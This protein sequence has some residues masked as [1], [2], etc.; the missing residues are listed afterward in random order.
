[1]NGRT[2][3]A[4]RDG[5]LG[6]WLFM[7]RIVHAI[8][9]RRLWDTYPYVA[10]ACRISQAGAVGFFHAL[11]GLFHFPAW[12]LPRNERFSSLARRVLSQRGGPSSPFPGAAGLFRF[13]SRC[14]RLSFALAGPG[15]HRV[16]SALP[17][18]RPSRPV[19]RTTGMSHMGFRSV[20]DK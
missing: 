13:P 20:K 14:H 16:L 9:E 17:A 18:Q 6:C 12:A 7:R 1:M 2:T 19:R 4:P 10:L 5:M 8:F 3:P 15:R 11:I